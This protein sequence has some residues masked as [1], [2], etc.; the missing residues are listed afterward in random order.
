MPDRSSLLALFF[1]LPL[2]AW[3]GLSLLYSELPGSWPAAAAA[4]FALASLAVFFLARPWKKALV[5][6]TLL[7]FIPVLAVFLLHKPSNTR[8]WQ[9]DL[10]VLPSATIE[11]DRVTIHNIRNC[12][13]RTETDFTVRYYDKTFDLKNLTSVDLYLVDWGLGSVVHTMLSFGFNNR[14]YVA[15]SIEA[16]K[17]HGE[18]YS[19]LRG[20]FRQY[21]LTY[22]VADE[23][24]VIRLRTNYRQ[25]ETVYLYRVRG[26]QPLYREVFLDYFRAINRLHDTPEWYNALL[27]NC[28]SVLRG[29]TRPY[30]RKVVWDWR[31]LANGYADQLAYEKGTL[32]TSLPFAEL[33]RQSIINAK[34][35]AADLDPDFSRRIREGLPGMALAAPAK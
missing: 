8:A 34:A 28:T 20:F 15:I 33:K 25:G 2:M 23:R 14:D 21:E 24:D 7:F 31:L 3:G 4:G 9:P 6:F 16:R 10:A 17:E 32:D 29:H 12:D 1:T 13:Y 5:L 35:R 19:T 11:G 26:D 30:Y 27:S 18:G 22:V